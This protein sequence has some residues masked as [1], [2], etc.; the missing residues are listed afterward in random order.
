[1]KTQTSKPFAGQRNRRRG[2]LQIDL[3]IGVAILS[4]AMIPLSVSFAREQRLLRAEYVRCVA[5]EI[6]DGEAEILAASSW[7]N[8]PD[9][10][11]AYSVKSKAADHLPPGR[12][13]LTKN[14]NHLRLEWTPERLHGVSAVVR[15]ITIK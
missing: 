7:N 6:V 1:M 3:V 12:F 2:F 5:D 13:E 4:L 14:G 8:V 9:G 15:E 11:Q 10:T